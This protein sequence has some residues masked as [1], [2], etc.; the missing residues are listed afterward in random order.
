LDKYRHLRI[1]YYT[2]EKWQGKVLTKSWLTFYAM[3]EKKHGSHF[4]GHVVRNV[5][6]ANRRNMKF[7]VE[8]TGALQ[9]YGASDNGL[10]IMHRFG[11]VV[12]MKTIKIAKAAGRVKYIAWVS[13]AVEHDNIS[14]WI[15]QYAK[16]FFTTIPR[17]MIGRYNPAKCSVAGVTISKYPN[18][19]I[20]MSFVFTDAGVRVD[21]WTTEVVTGKYIGLADSKVKALHKKTAGVRFW[22]DYYYNSEALV[23][24]TAPPKGHAE[25]L[26]D[27]AN[28]DGRVQVRP[29][30]IYHSDVV[31]NEGF[32]GAMLELRERMKYKFDNNKYFLL[33]MD[34]DLYLKFYTKAMSRPRMFRKLCVNMVLL[35]PWWHSCKICT[36]KVV[37]Y[38]F[39]TIIA[40]AYVAAYPDSPTV[41]AQLP[42]QAM[43]HFLALLSLSYAKVR[44]RFLPLY[45]SLPRSKSI[46]ALYQFFEYLLP[47]VRAK[48][49]P[50]PDAVLF[51][52]NSGFQGGGFSS[53][54]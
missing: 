7:L 46:I 52:P 42:H 18:D 4:V 8:I 16:A 28:P 20:D 47:F 6:G 5:Y 22:E 23:N 54:R 49:N 37:Q 11:A 40:P 13:E 9:S 38:H 10:Q 25:E 32:I 24:F 39:K 51:S 48:R 34:I 19:P 12:S 50:G 2:I 30:D 36:S 53:G 35:L 17:D 45:D 41:G 31:R 26:E 29:F 1:K 43:E 21:S 33:K 3:L 14:I 15:D 44:Y 27:K